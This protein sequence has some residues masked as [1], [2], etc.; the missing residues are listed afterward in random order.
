MRSSS[1]PP[2]S[3]THPTS[4]LTNTSA[5]KQSGSGKGRRSP[6]RNEG[7]KA[8]SETDGES[9]RDDSSFAGSTNLN[10]GSYGKAGMARD[11]SAPRE[12]SVI[13][14]IDSPTSTASH[15]VS[16]STTHSLPSTS[17]LLPPYFHSAVLPSSDTLPQTLFFGGGVRDFTASLQQRNLPMTLQQSAQ[18]SIHSQSLWQQSELSNHSAPA[19]FTV[20][21]TS[22]MAISSAHSSPVSQSVASFVREATNFSGPVAVPGESPGA[23]SPFLG[24]PHGLQMNPD[25]FACKPLHMGEQMQ[26]DPRCFPQG[27]EQAQE[28]T[29]RTQHVY[30]MH[31]SQQIINGGQIR[32]AGQM[33]GQTLSLQSIQHQQQLHL[34]RRDNPEGFL[35]THQALVDQYG[36]VVNTNPEMLETHSD[37]EFV[38]YSSGNEGSSYATAST[39]SINQMRPRSLT[40][41]R[42]ETPLGSILSTGADAIAQEDNNQMQYI[43]TQVLFDPT[44]Y[45]LAQRLSNEASFQQERRLQQQRKQE[46]QALGTSV[47]SSS[48][49][50]KPLL[51]PK[52][53]PK[54]GCSAYP[55]PTSSSV[56][57]T[58]SSTDGSGKD[59]KGSSKSK[60]SSSGGRRSKA[61]T[62]ESKATRTLF[63]CNEPDCGKTFTRPF[64]LRSHLDTHA[65][66][67]PHRCIDLVG[68]ENGACSYDFTRR[69]DLVRHVKAK[70]RDVYEVLLA[71]STRKKAAKKTTEEST[72]DVNNDDEHQHHYLHHIDGGS[73]TTDSDAEE[74]DEDDV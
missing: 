53:K 20:P 32:Q 64:N 59:S 30:Q 25:Y 74:E 8:S 61:S 52:T 13:S 73:D 11:Q 9:E 19:G 24:S 10:R 58:S 21:V 37:D 35:G 12:S 31:P 50:T 71:T 23:L 47:S 45:T 39:G 3:S 49:S 57:S 44:A 69:H 70:H 36:L 40:A 60:S 4:E 51:L 16:P 1:F 34:E 17:P 66:I 22:T 48:K 27:E 43:H 6:S 28:N 62:P 14:Y 46:A 55:Y 65:G 68:V 15:S 2:E 67:R 54:Q 29:L 18:G 5:I 41:P 33:S 42:S 72:M 7:V 38:L 26:V 56:D 63:T